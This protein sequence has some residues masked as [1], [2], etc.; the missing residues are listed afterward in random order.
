MGKIIWLHYPSHPPFHFY[1]RC[2][3]AGGGAHCNKLEFLFDILWSSQVLKG[4][5]EKK[6]SDDNYIHINSLEFC[7]VVIQLVA[8]IVCLHTLTP[9]QLHHFFPS[10]IPAQPV[11][12]CLTDDTA[13]MAWANKVTSKSLQG[14]SLL[15]IFTGLLRT[16]N[17]GYNTNHLAGILNCRAD[18]LSHPT[19]PYLL[20]AARHEQIYQKHKYL[21]EYLIYCRCYC[22]IN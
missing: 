18:N 6:P 15:G 5:N 2:Q 11:C 7:I 19:F 17:L 22:Y 9:T 3:Q 21:L 10:G 4:V 1:W 20:F 8:V 13:S 12:L 14:Q 16:A